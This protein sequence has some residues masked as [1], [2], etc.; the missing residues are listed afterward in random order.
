MCAVGR[1]FANDS[2]GV[3][4]HEVGVVGPHR[5]HEAPGD[6]DR[7]L[8]VG[9]K[10]H[11]EGE[12]PGLVVQESEARVGV[13]PDDRVRVRRR[14]GLD[15]HTALRG[16]H[17]QDAPLGAVKDGGEVELLDDVGGRPDQDLAHGH[18]LDVHAQDGAGDQLGLFG[19]AGELHP[20]RL[21][22]AADQDLGL[23]DDLPGASGEEGLGGLAG[24]VS[25]MRDGPGG[26]RQAL[27]D[28]QG[29]GVGFLE[30]HARRTLA[31]GAGRIGRVDGTALGV[32]ETRPDRL[33]GWGS[34]Q[35]RSP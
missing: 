31:C 13:H 2:Q 29:L 6:P 33:A 9:A 26:D 27:G 22:A 23:D 14:D 5:G 7:V 21:A 1:R 8:L 30:F 28:E 10:A 4:L 18:A 11:R 24:L 12:L 16:A 15:L 35:R 34:W 17:Q 32:V 20:A 3:D 25:A 19:E